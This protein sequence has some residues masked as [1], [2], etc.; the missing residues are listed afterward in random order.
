MEGIDLRKKEEQRFHNF[1][2]KLLKTDYD[3]AVKH[4]ASNEKWYSISRRSRDFSNKWLSDHCKHKKV[5]DYC[6]GN[7]ELAALAI[8]M[9]AEQVV[10]IDISDFSIENAKKN[11]IK[12]GI[13]D[14]AVFLVMDAE[15]MNF[16]DR[17]FDIIYVS[18]VLHHLDIRKAYQE[19][20]RVLKPDGKIIC[21]EALAHNKI[22]QMYRRKTPHLRTKWEA[23]HIMHKRDID[24]A[25]EYFD[26]VK[27]LGF[28]HLISIL[29][30]PLRET[31]LF[32]FV[33]SI[34]EAA[35]HLLLKLPVI[36]WQAWQVIFEL[37]LPRNR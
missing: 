25:Y 23:E 12:G 15:N 3:K 35:D 10:G 27:L 37:S 22:I 6:C 31:R 17:T 13:S 8:D 20:G 16:K 5:L 33:L 2:R 18:G 4:Y 29:A 1:V 30:V 21:I 11:A 9:C 26:S 36:K 24:L 34:F 32:P 19:L 28:F 14:K 7:G